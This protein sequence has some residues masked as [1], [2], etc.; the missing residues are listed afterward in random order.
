MSFDPNHERNVL[1]Q[2][3]QDKALAQA[4]AARIAQAADH[5][6]KVKVWDV[7][8]GER[9]TLWAIDAREQIERG[10][11]ALEPPLPQPPEAEP[12][13]QPPEPEPAPQPPEIEPADPQPT[14]PPEEADSPVL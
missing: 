4:R 5:E 10:L 14:P 6:G 7:Q 8:T 3:A 2:R 12:T 1:A 9:K 11:V 13:P